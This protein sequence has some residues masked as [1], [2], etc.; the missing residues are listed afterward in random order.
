M[1][2]LYIFLNLFI[3]ELIFIFGPIITGAPGQRQNGKTGKQTDLV[4]L[5][6]SFFDFVFKTEK[7]KNQ[8]SKFCF[9]VFLILEKQKNQISKLVFWFF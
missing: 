9:L 7:R 5:K 8:I 3:Y 6:F 2:F 4:F 1:Y